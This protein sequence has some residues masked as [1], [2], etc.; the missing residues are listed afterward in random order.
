M[1]YSHKDK[2]DERVVKHST[3]PLEYP[4]KVDEAPDQPGV[5]L[6]ID[7]KDNLVH[8][9]AA[10][11]EGL[12]NSIK[13]DTNVASTNEVTHYRWFITKDLDVANELKTDWINKYQL[14]Q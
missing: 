1:R 11:S 3:Y 2:K 8:V 14:N 4:A 5:Y 12:K 13:V 9:G 10:S 7:S 6:F